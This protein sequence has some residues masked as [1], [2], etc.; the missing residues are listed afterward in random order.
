MNIAS[1]YAQQLESIAP[2]LYTVV[3]R[4]FMP[5]G[6]N[7]PSN[8]RTLKSNP[9]SRLAAKRTA[10]L[11]RLEG[12]DYLVTVHVHPRLSLPTTNTDEIIRLPKIRL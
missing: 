10:E 8:R 5:G 6:E 9:S 7:L 4:W 1:L 11:F 2:Q 12:E 3:A